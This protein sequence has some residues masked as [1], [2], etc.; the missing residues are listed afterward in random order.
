M[1]PDAL[2][3]LEAALVYMLDNH[4]PADPHPGTSAL[5]REAESKFIS[6]YDMDVSDAI[7]LLSKFSIHK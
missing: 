1:D 7:L 4:I 3:R 5:I 2:K 6:D